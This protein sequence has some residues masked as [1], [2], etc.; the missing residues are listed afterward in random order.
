MLGNINIEAGESTY[1]QSSKSNS[2]NLGGSVG[3]NGLSANIGFNESQSS[4]DQT[5]F[6]NSQISAINGN[7][8]INTKQDLKIFGANLLSKNV[9]LNIGNNFLLKSRQNLSESDSYNIGAS[10]GL[11]GDSSGINGG[12]LG[13][14]LGNGYSNRAFIDQAS[15]IIGTNS[16][17]INVANDT[18][19]TSAL[20]A[21]QNNQGIDLGNLNLKTKSLT[22]S[23]LNNFSVSE[24]NQLSTNLQ[25]G[26]N[27][28][29]P[30][31]NGN[32]A[33]KLNMQGKESSSTTKATIGKGNITINEILNDESKIANL[34]RE[35]NDIE[36]NKKTVITSDFDSEIKIDLRL[37]ASAGNLMI[38][39]TDKAV[40][41]WNSYA[42]ETKKGFNISYDALAI[43]LNSLGETVSGD[44][45]ASDA[46][47]ATGKNYQNLYQL[48][49]NQNIGL[50]DLAGEGK[51]ITYN[52]DQLDATSESKYANG[53]YDRNSDTAVINSDSNKSDSI[54]AGT[55]AHEGGHRMF[56]NIGQSYTLSEENASHMI[57]NFAESRW[58][59]YQSDNTSLRSSLPTP[60]LN[61]SN[62]FYANNVEFGVEVNPLL[63][64]VIPTLA[65]AYFAYKGEGNALKGMSD[66]NRALMNSDAGKAILFKTVIIS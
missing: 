42:T 27:P 32:L 18:N 26:Y 50:E 8:N 38:G 1:S 21:N 41:N 6:A 29:N 7:L 17:N 47:L 15:S 13:L 31:Q 9:N 61:F 58:D 16:V 40:A 57:G 35:I 23:D 24:S 56:N 51:L 5:T 63:H 65:T 43:P 66:T 34:N 20:I 44:L 19:I 30:T 25:A 59:T 52:G 46:L 2:R 64:V 14:N 45:N 12:S 55:L 10:I 33:I 48:A 3:T 28:N 4:F 22:Y 11:S 54:L 53:F 37:I 49:Y 60:T 36:Q 62:N 39:N